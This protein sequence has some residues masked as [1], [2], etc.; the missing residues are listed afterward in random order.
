MGMKKTLFAAT[1]IA[2]LG[3]SSAAFAADLAYK[4]APAPYAPMYSWT[5]FY[6]GAN[7]GGAW[8]SGTLTDNLT[9]AS[10]TGNNSGVIGGGTVG[11]NWQVSPSFVLGVEGTFDGTSISHTTNS[12]GTPW[13]TF[14]GSANTNWVSTIAGRAGISQY[15]W[16]FYVKGGGGWVDNSATLS[17]LTTGTSITAS[18][19]NSGWLVGAGIEYGMTRN[20]SLKVEYDYLDLSNWTTSTPFRSGDNLSLS[21]QINMFTV[22]A[23]YRF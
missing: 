21:R 16:L 18:N 9:G 11:Y 17:N 6:L 14:Q 5:G 22:G 13:G 7:L 19:T 1:A 10:I 12:V 20:W 3:A 23:N 8:A 4:A 2:L 15:N